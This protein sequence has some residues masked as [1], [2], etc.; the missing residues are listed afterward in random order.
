MTSISLIL[1][2]GAGLIATH[3]A[4]SETEP[5]APDRQLV[6]VPTSM[7]AGASLQLVSLGVAE[8]TTEDGVTIPT[9][10][11]R[12]AVANIARDRPWA[13]DTSKARV[14]VEAEAAAIAPTFVNSDVP[15]L[16]IVILDPSERRTI[17]L[18]FALTPE[19]AARG[20][21][22]TF[23]L[24][25]PV[26]TPTRAM[27]YA[28]FERSTAIAQSMREIAL[29][30]GWGCNWWFDPSYAW[31]TYFHRPGPARPR[32]PSYARITKAPRWAEPVAA[33][34]AAPLARQGECEQW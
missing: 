2:T 10:H 15:T 9:L 17:D 26:N 29:A 21:P 1:V 7:N 27:Q 20:G 19:V 13:F 14:E 25:W 5:A 34:L 4:F 8:L 6:V 11:V 24:R 12:A 32:P 33:P 3:R 16:P 30:A 22:A 31:S 23:V 18:Y 28:R